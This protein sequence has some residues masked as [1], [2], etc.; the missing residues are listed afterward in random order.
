MTPPITP[1]W[2]EPRDGRLNIAPDNGSIFAV[3]DFIR[4]FE[5]ELLRLFSE[6]AVAGTTHTC[7]GQE[8]SQLAVARALKAEDHLLSNHRNHGHFLAFT[9]NADGLLA[10]ILGREGAVCGGRGGSQHLAVGHFH[11]SGVQGG[12]TGIAAGIA[13]A[14]KFRNGDGIVAV[15]I[16]DGTLGEGLVYEA[17][18]IAGIWSLPVIF[19]VENNGIAQTTPTNTTIAGTIETRGRAF[20]LQVST[21]DDAASSFVADVDAAAAWVRHNRKPG[22]LI[23]NTARLGPHSKGDDDRPADEM[24]LIRARDPL[25]ALRSSISDND[26]RNIEDEN[27]RYLKALSVSVLTRSVIEGSRL[28]QAPTLPCGRSLKAEEPSISVRES[29]N[30]SLRRLLTE[31][32]NVILLGEDL[33]DPYGGAFKVTTGLSSGFPGRVL[34][35]PISEAGVTGTA[36][37]LAMSGYRPIME[38]MFADFLTLCM[39]QL[40][41]HA[42]KLGTIAGDAAVPLVVRTPSGGRRGYGPTHSQSPESLAASIPG[43]TVLCPNHRLNAGALLENAVQSTHGPVLFVEHKLQ[44]S[45]P[46][47]AGAFTL[48]PGETTNSLDTLYPTCARLYEE[49]DLII[50]AWGGMLVEAEAAATVLEEEDELNVEILAPTLLSPLPLAGLIE[51]IRRCERLVIAEEGPRAFGIGAELVGSLADAGVTPRVK[52]LGQEQTII[53]AARGL[54][55]HVIPGAPHIIAAARDLF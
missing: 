47:E 9:G 1:H 21:L 44:Y 26:A 43:L 38:V 39:D 19:V 53:P 50:L 32:E 22:F 27:A 49:P 16:G 28:A 54:E 11:S 14:E 40:Y 13:A 4:R 36:I 45:R 5:T 29:L 46:I 8:L 48:L 17:M 12:M 55:I 24:E 10:E 20:G 23:V 7:L 51:R 35:T 2:L 3:A 41:N 33:H 6:G 34:S 42:V 25:R 52:R 30:R 37:G 18:N 31:N 15:V